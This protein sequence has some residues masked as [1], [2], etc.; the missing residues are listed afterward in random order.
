VECHGAKGTGSTERRSQP[1]IPDFTDAH[2]QARR[3][4]AQLMSSILDGKGPDMPPQRGEITEQEVRGLV[5]YVRPFARSGRSPNR[6]E[7]KGPAIDPTT[8]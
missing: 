3:T 5:A 6:E 7:L 1:E 8:R 2:W 4:D